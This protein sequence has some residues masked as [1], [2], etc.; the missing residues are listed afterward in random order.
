MNLQLSIE[1][2]NALNDGTY[3]VYNP[4]PFVSRGIQI[5]GRNEAI[6]RFGRR[7]QLGAKLAF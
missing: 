2:F 7:W 3:Q 4:S 6:R 5:N 1:V